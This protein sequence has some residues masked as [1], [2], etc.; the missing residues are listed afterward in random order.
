MSLTVRLAGVHY[1]GEPAVEVLGSVFGP[2]YNADD[3]DGTAIY[4]VE[5]EGG[6]LATPLVAAQRFKAMPAFRQ[7]ERGPMWAWNGD[8]AKPTLTVSFGWLNFDGQWT[9]HL[10]LREGRIVDAGDARAHP[11]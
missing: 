11:V 2:D 5:G 10:Y 1:R 9:L 6:G 3:R 4:V 7:D 8:R